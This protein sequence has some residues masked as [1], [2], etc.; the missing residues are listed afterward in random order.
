M[1]LTLVP[2]RGLTTR[3]T[4]VKYKTSITY[5]SKV[6]ANVKSFLLTNRQKGKQTDKAKTI[7][8]DASAVEG[9][10]IHKLEG[11]VGPVSL[12]WL[13]HKIPTCQTYQYLAN[14]F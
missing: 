11:H 12:H 1:T 10:R 8:P 9:G 7:F 4:H 3:N 13:I 5:R 14:W 2:K 6:M